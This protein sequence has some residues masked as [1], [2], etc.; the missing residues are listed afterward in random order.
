LKGP[1][2]F[3]Q[4]FAPSLPQIGFRPASSACASL[5][6]AG[7][8]RTLFSPSIRTTGLVSAFTNLR[9]GERCEDESALLAAILADAYIRPET[10]Q[11]ALARI[12]DAHHRLPIAA[13]SAGGGVAAGRD[14]AAVRDA[15]AARGLSAAEQLD[16]ALQELGRIEFGTEGSVRPHVHQAFALSVVQLTTDALSSRLPSPGSLAPSCSRTTMNG[17]YS[18]PAT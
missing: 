9:T 7:S 12:I 18:A 6:A 5:R 2:G 3:A 16:L 17:V 8:P 11:A 13:I 10:Y 1:R 14:R 15:E 4:G